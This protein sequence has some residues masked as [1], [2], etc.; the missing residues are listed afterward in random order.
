MAQSGAVRQQ[1]LVRFMQSTPLG[2]RGVVL[3]LWRDHRWQACKPS[4]L[5]PA[6]MQRCRTGLDNLNAKYAAQHQTNRSCRP[7]FGSTWRRHQVAPP[8][9]SLVPA[10]AG[11]RLVSFARFDKRYPLYCRPQAGQDLP[12]DFVTRLKKPGT[13]SHLRPLYSL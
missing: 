8:P 12:L 5:L 7:S 3:P 6:P 9:P 4:P 11:R 1:Q 13:Q 2:R 10:V